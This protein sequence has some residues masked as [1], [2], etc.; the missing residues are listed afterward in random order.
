MPGAWEFRGSYLEAPYR[1]GV[2]Y[3]C[4]YDRGAKQV[5]RRSLR[6]TDFE[7]AKS[8]LVALVAAQP[9]AAGREASAADVLTVHALAA[10]LEGPA[11]Q[12][13]SAD[14]SE[15]VGAIVGQYLTEIG[16]PELPVAGWT[17]SRQLAAA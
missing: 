6:T 1:G 8:R 3:A 13:R 11:M 16:K 14:Y 12:T 9:A 2:W 17:P 5:S 10:Y 4:R 7:E 15:R